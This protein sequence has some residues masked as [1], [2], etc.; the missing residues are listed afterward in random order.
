M[1]K[2]IRFYVPNRHR[3]NAKWVP[4]ENRGKIIEIRRRKSA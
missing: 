3:K 1:A 4:V 2:L